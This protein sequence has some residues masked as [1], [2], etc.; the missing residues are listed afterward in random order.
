M[1]RIGARQVWSL[2][3]LMLVAI[4]AYALG[5][6]VNTPRSPEVK[7]PEG[8]WTVLVDDLP[9][10]RVVECVAARGTT[11]QGGVGVSITCDWS[12]ATKVTR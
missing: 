3:A 5:A 6:F 7:A 9:S 2:V 4:V 12:T 11:P 10:G 8:I 1:A